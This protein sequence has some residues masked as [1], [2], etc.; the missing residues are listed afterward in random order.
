MTRLG[1]REA[2]MAT[3]H[4]SHQRE[5]VLLLC[6]SKAA[7]IGIQVSRNIIQKKSPSLRS[8]GYHHVV[9]TYLA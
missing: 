6:I 8:I 3:A 1:I 4:K 2:L 9:L 7:L 5:V